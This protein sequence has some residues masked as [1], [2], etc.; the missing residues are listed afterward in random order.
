MFSAVSYEQ[1][2]MITDE[3]K[4]IPLKNLNALD[5]TELCELSEYCQHKLMYY[6]F[7]PWNKF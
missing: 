3:N 4:N 1:D 6:F 7:D 5:Y 2:K